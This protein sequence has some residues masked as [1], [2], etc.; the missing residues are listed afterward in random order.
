MLYVCISWKCFSGK[1]IIKPWVWPFY[2]VFWLSYHYSFS[3]IVEYGAYLVY[4]ILKTNN[5]LK[6]KDEILWNKNT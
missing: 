5:T 3:V 1:K 6:A 2:I 4:I